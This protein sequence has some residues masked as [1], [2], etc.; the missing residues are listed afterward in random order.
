M[1]GI[2]DGRREYADDMG[3]AQCEAC[4]A[5]YSPMPG[6][7]NDGHQCDDD[8]TKA[9]YMVPLTHKSLSELGYTR[10]ESEVAIREWDQQMLD[11][12]G[13]RIQR[14]HPDDQTV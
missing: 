13:I 2:D 8:G 6:W 11:Q 10:E 4:G 7:V 3:Y 14:P 5:V 12:H 9:K 1:V